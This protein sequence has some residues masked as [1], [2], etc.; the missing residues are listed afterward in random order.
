MM[1]MSPNIATM[2]QVYRAALEA[3][4]DGNVEAFITTKALDFLVIRDS[5]FSAE[6]L[7]Q[8]ETSFWLELA[9][10]YPPWRPV[11]EVTYWVAEGA[12]DAATA[13][14]VALEADNRHTPDSTRLFSMVLSSLENTD[15]Q[16]TLEAMQQ[17]ALESLQLT[18]YKPPSIR[19]Y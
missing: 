19:A 8:Q 3:F 16:G 4:T 13:R 14:L 7:R 11:A 15:G 1:D 5:F 9:E 17:G 18:A 6:I 10:K 2:R 12:S